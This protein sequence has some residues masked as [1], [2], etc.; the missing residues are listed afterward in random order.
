M[1]LYI[2]Q[3][4]VDGSHYVGISKDPLFRLSYHN[5]GKVRSTKHKR[6]WVIVYT[7]KHGSTAEARKREKFLKSYAGAK[8]KMNIIASIA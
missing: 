7:E 4:E 2:L 5:T 8:E 1:H 6:P 3:S